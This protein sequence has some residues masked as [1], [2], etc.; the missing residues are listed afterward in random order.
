ML[1]HKQ[2]YV[3][4]REEKHILQN[5]VKYEQIKKPPKY[6]SLSAQRR[7]MAAPEKNHNN[8]KV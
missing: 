4:G 5:E 6:V 2:I 8:Y 3:Y 1:Q 7:A